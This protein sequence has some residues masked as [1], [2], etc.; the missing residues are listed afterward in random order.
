WR[1]AA[2]LPGGRDVCGATPGRGGTGPRPRSQ[3]STSPGG[4]ACPRNCCPFTL[5]PVHTGGPGRPLTVRAADR[6]ACAG[7]P[8]GSYL[9]DPR[10]VGTAAN[11]PIPEGEYTFTATQITRSPP[12]SRA[13]CSWVAATPTWRAAPCTARTGA[14]AGSP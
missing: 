7:T 9:N 14:P 1:E 4:L 13:G 11:E 3:W 2:G 10:Y 12:P 8:N 5:L 6:R